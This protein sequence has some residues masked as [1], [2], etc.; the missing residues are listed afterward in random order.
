MLR[1]T[2]AWHGGLERDPRRIAEGASLADVATLR[3]A[4]QQTAGVEPAQLLLSGAWACCLVALEP[5]DRLAVEQAEQVFN[6]GV[7]Q[8]AGS[9]AINVFRCGKHIRLDDRA[10]AAA[11]VPDWLK[12]PPTRKVDGLYRYVRYLCTLKDAVE[13]NLWGVMWENAKPGPCLLGDRMAANI[14]VVDRSY[15]F[16]PCCS[17]S[18]APQVQQFSLQFALPPQSGFSQSPAA[19]PFL[20]LGDVVRAHRVRADRKPPRYM[21]VRSQRH[22]ASVAFR[23]VKAGGADDDAEDGATDGN[24]NVEFACMSLSGSGSDT[25]TEADIARANELSSWVRGRLS[26]ESMSSYITTIAE[27][28][29][30]SF[31]D[32]V[33][34][35]LEVY[36]EEYMFVVSDGSTDGHVQVQASQ[37]APAA[38][39]LFA[40]AEVGMW[41]KLRAVSAEVPGAP[42]LANAALVTQVPDW[43]LDVVERARTMP[44]MPSSLGGLPSHST[45]SEAGQAVGVAASRV[46]AEAPLQQQ[47]VARPQHPPETA[48]DSRTPHHPHTDRVGSASAI[49][50]AHAEEGPAQG[51]NS[52]LNTRASGLDSTV[53]EPASKVVTARETEEDDVVDRLGA[54][55][56]VNV[57]IEESG[58]PADGVQLEAV[59][60][61]VVDMAAQLYSEV[62]DAA[63]DMPTPML[64]VEVN[65]TPHPEEV[66]HFATVYG[67]TQDPSR[68][69]AIHAE[70]ASRCHVLG[71][72]LIA[73]VC[74][75]SGPTGS[76]EDLIRACCY[77]CGHSFAWNVA[78]EDVRAAKR[79]RLALPCGHWA[80]RLEYRCRLQ[81]RDQDCASEQIEVLVSDPRGEL[82]TC[83]PEQV[84][85]DEGVRRRA[86]CRFAALLNHGV[87]SSGSPLESRHVLAVHRVDGPAYPNGGFVVCDTVAVDTAY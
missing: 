28:H 2:V 53:S 29:A 46:V 65:S 16:F 10:I 77:A 1:G 34:R 42:I 50:P 82:F 23:A 64:T 74:G 7:W 37:P 68:I 70:S 63:G 83:P 55:E 86:Q 43:C 75:A 66:T 49:P 8:V 24:T 69:R 56:V 39:W 6:T 87:S 84:V 31:R 58:R 54:E 3:V 4:V 67:A 35:V 78:G 33:V 47:D 13:V 19:L 71:H 73:Q 32:L 25:Y 51:A 45:G 60:A 5:G 85:A 11:Q 62:I 9:T 20:C 72:F 15:D 38:E 41:L 30:G 44:P 61:K 40:H 22:S 26:R 57:K 48:L 14:I 18:S 80:F 36:T 12:I 59:G 27:L 81:L 17:W 21:N 79:R 52:L 76:I